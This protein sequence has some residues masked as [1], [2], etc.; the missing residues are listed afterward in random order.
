MKYDREDIREQFKDLFEKSLD[1][2]YVND[3][4]GKILDANN[5]ALNTLGYTR[6][7]I[8][9]LFFINLI[10]EEQLKKAFKYTKEIIETGKQSE[11]SEYKL[12]TKDGNFI[13]VETYGIPLKKNGMPYAILGIGNDITEQKIADQ[14]L[15]ESEERFRALFKGGIVP[16]Y[17][18]QKRGNDFELINYNDAAEKFTLGEVKNYLGIKASEMYVDRPDILKDLHTCFAKKTNIIREMIYYIQ[19]LKEEKD[20]LAEY[21][22]IPPDLVLVHTEDITKR[23]NAETKLLESEEKYRLIS[24]NAYDLISILNKKFK[25]EYINEQAFKHILGYSKNDL[26]GKSAIKFCH[27]KDAENTT[28][29]LF[30]GFKEGIGG[31]DLRFKHKNGHWVYLES[32]GS[33]FVDVDGELKALVISRDITDRKN[34]EILV[35]EE[36]KKLKELDQLRKN[37]IIRISHELKTPLIPVCGGAE[38]LLDKYKDRLEKDI[39]EIIEMIGRGGQRLKTLINKLLDLSKL[40]YDMLSLVKQRADLSKIIKEISNDMMHLIKKRDL[41]LNLE[42]P[43]KLV[44]NIDS[45]RIEQ[46]ITNLLSNAIK[47]TPPKGKITINLQKE[48]KWAKLIVNDT[49]IGLT[50]KEINILFNRFGKIERHENGLEYIDITGS[51]LG[52]F[53]SKEIIDLHGGKIWVE[54]LGRNKGCTFYVKLPIK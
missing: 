50:E 32:K 40:E 49:G 48:G 51:G 53:I 39:N 46:V 4:D 3:L 2:I 54:S 11:R 5:I 1:L 18:W 12:K 14:K 36:I 7:E 9:N 35:K 27:P 20:L 45:I 43:D 37:L 38:F 52:L 8:Q 15:K 17:T 22:F 24:E 13:Y 34:A 44:L 25:Y 6:E 16:S 29:A 41:I 47:N 30:E 42:I 31:I 28:R 21:G 26:I 33:T 23:K 19:I 10:D